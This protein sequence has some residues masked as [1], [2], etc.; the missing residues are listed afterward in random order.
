VPLLIVDG[1]P[2]EG[3]DTHNVAATAVDSSSGATVPWTGTGNYTYT[4]AMTTDLS[5]FVKISGSAVGLTTSASSLNLGETAPPGGHFGP[6]G[7]SFTPATSQP[8][9]AA[10]QTPGTETITDSIGT[11]NPG[12]DAGSDFVSVGGDPVLLDQDPID[13]CDGTGAKG[14][15]T[16]TAS[17]QSFVT[18]S[19]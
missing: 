12:S 5:T 17:T 16:V 4:G 8:T 6:S 1:D 7:S 10:T 11:G 9:T 13:T 2:V 14:N 3:T 18:A 15:S 19:A